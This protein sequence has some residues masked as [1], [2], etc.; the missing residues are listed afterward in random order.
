[1]TMGNR[2]RRLREDKIPKWTQQDVA[3]ALTR[4]GVK[5]RREQVATWELGQWPVPATIGVLA[6]IFETTTDYIITGITSSDQLDE[7]EKDLIGAM[8]A[9][10]RLLALMV[11]A[12][13][14]REDQIDGIFTIAKTVSRFAGAERQEAPEREKKIS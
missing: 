10:P 2:L 6:Q 12:K 5:T 13:R 7:V 14:L 8:R 4:C 1:M 3:D 11:V 9:N